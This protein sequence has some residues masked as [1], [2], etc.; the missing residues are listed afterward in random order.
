MSAACAVH[1]ALHLQSTTLPARHPA[2]TAQACPWLNHFFP[3]ICHVPLRKRV[4]HSSLARANVI[5]TALTLVTRNA[6]WR[7]ATANAARAAGRP[8]VG[9]DI[10]QAYACNLE[11]S[12]RCSR[13][14]DGHSQI[15]SSYG[16]GFGSR[17]PACNTHVAS[18]EEGRK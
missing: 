11:R 4:W 5:R 2:H 10:F 14:Y 16:T 8:S 9:D 17:G 13:P 1:P 15:V 6:N 18:H 3:P 7:H 12:A